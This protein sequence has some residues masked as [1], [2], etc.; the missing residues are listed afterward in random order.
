M[1]DESVANRALSGAGHV[2]VGVGIEL[3]RAI[4]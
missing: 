1:P 3:G 2:V 4:R